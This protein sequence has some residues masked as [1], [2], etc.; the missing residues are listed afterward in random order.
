MLD[1]RQLAHLEKLNLVYGRVWTSMRVPDSKMNDVRLSPDATSA[2][3]FTRSTGYLVPVPQSPVQ[4]HR[5]QALLMTYCIQLATAVL[6]VMQSMGTLS[7]PLTQD[8]C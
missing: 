6:I 1:T 7:D 5:H 3:K 2:K 8:E 4:G